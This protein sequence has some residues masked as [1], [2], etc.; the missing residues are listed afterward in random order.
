MESTDEL[1]TTAQV[2]EVLG[3]SIKTVLRI[4][5]RGD[6]P[7]AVRMPGLRGPRMYRLADVQALVDRRSA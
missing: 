4:A 7:V 1:L 5:E 6:L 2:A 3:V